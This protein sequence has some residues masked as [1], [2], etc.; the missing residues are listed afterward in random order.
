MRP[1][2]LLSSPAVRLESPYRFELYHIGNG[3]TRHDPLLF[4]DRP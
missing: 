2:A 4:T 3:G 1:C